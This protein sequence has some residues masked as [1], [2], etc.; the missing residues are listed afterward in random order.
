[1]RDMF[2][3]AQLP[4]TALQRSDTPNANANTSIA[5]GA[6][7]ASPIVSDISAKVVKEAHGTSG[8]RRNQEVAT[9]MH[10]KVVDAVQEL[11]QVGV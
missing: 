3:P 11:G 2:G 9:D 8:R 1:M 5:S 7:K 10:A 4:V 6:A